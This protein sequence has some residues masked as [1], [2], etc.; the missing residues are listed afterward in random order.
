MKLVS[1]GLLATL[2]SF[3]ATAAPAYAQGSEPA[4]GAAIGE[5]IIAT[6]GALLLTAALLH[7]G[8]G[9]RS[10]RVKTLGALAAFSSRQ[11]GL[12]GWAAL[13]SAIAGVSLMLAV[14]GMYW[15]ISLHID[16]GRDEGPLANPAHYFILAGLFG[17]FS[18]G[19]VA[20]VLPKRSPGPTAVRIARDWE[21]PLGGVLI[22]ACGAF[23]LM[24]FPLDD[25][26]HRLFGQDVTLWGPTHLMLIGGASM[27]LLG[28]AV[29]LVEGLRANRD[30]GRADREVGWMMRV[31]AVSLAGGLLV[32]LS[33]FQAEFD[34]GVPQFRFVLQP[35]LIMLAAGVGLVTVRLWAGRGTALGAVA[36]FL[37]LR[38]GLALTVGPVLGETTPHFP[39]YVVEALVV[40]GVALLLSAERRPLAFGLW[41]GAGI[42][43]L[44]LAAE[45]GWS[46]VWM[47]IP[48]PAELLPEAAL[49]GFATAI[50]GGVLGAWIG[51]HL[52]VTPR[53]RSP[54]LRGGAVVAAAALA[55]MLGVAL[56]K[57]AD[58]GVRADLTLTDVSP[59]P[60]RRVAADVRLDPAD[61]AD[62]AEWLTVTAW[63]GGR[64]RGRPARA[65]RPRPLPDHEADPGAR[66]VEGPD[67]PSLGQLADGP[68][69]L[70]AARQRDPGQ[71]SAGADELLA[72][73][74][75]R[76]RD[77]PARAEVDRRRPHGDRLRHRAG[78]RAEPV[79]ATGVGS[80]PA[81]GSA[82]AAAAGATAPSAGVGGTALQ[83][84]EPRYRL[85]VRHWRVAPAGR[86]RFA[87]EATIGESHP[88][89]ERNSPF[90]Y[91]A[92]R[93]PG[94]ERA[95]GLPTPAPALRPDRTAARAPPR[96]S[97]TRRRS[98]SRPRCPGRRAQVGGAHRR[99][100]AR[101]CSHSRRW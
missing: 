79:R 97:P 68:A 40:E 86:V 60:E 39:L 85:A 17:I 91:P 32:A 24:G 46:H 63:Q 64:P 6:S 47:P 58:E 29:L 41:A 49:F 48:W 82:R 37:A 80:A 16:V 101:R 8:M 54:R 89:S 77:P 26:W 31:R 66:R 38:G 99:S 69:D 11:S 36:F 22:C 7:F 72:H 98:R 50:V 12:P 100:S 93:S 53:P 28:I 21:A 78:D 87:T 19:F 44:G 83:A 56:Y 62:D 5:V 55:A 18:A 75:S 34:F 81:G 90:P 84:T 95:S 1:K 2:A 74:H 65:H 45:W 59:P 51:S 88:D 15:D 52:A 13:P 57:P 94:S 3:A 14:F 70:P 23:A 92:Q 67:P 20:M 42:G 76:P 27:T 30:R 33:T 96:R 25:L 43:T 35:M 71:G 4:G 73:V 61:A 9:H 10:G